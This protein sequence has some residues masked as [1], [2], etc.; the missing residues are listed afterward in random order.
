MK[1]FMTLMAGL[2]MY[3]GLREVLIFPVPVLLA[4]SLFCALS[5]FH[6]K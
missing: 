2:L 5:T 6:F 4:G 1:L 3:M